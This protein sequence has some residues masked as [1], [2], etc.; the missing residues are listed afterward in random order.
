MVGDQACQTWLEALPEQPSSPIQRME[1]SVSD[2]RG[3]ADVMQ[4]SSS[5]EQFRV[6]ADEPAK[7]L[8]L[9]PDG[10]HVLPPARKSHRQALLRESSGSV[11]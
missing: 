1:A 4:P 11:S 5:S 3:V 8:S 10:L 6:I 7:T 2:V 9:R